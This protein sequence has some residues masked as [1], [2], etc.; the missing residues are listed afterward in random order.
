MEQ[1]SYQCSKTKPC[2]PMIPGS[3][4]M[5]KT[6]I[7]P[8]NV[9]KVSGRVMTIMP[10]PIPQVPT[11]KGITYEPVPVVVDSAMVVGESSMNVGMIFAGVGL[12]GIGAMIFMKMKKKKKKK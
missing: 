12:L 5:K 8:P 6:K 4:P 2:H 7:G 1:Q 3:M 9:G 11:E 10:G